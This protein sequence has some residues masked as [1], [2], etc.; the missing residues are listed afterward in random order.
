MTA[1]EGRLAGRQFLWLAPG[2]CL[3]LSALVLIYV[4]HSLG[5]AFG[6]A[7][8]RIRLGLAATLVVHILAIGVLWRV[9]LRRKPELA[10]SRTGLF[11]HWAILGTLAGALVKI[12]FTLGPTLFLSA[13]L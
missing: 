12:V 7:P 3:W 13:C 10:E 9:E 1:A 2:F 5:C 8:G 6:W 4:I 11:L